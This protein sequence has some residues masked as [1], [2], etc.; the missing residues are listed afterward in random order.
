M[1]HAAPSP[2]HG[3]LP[4]RTDHGPR[5]L[6]RVAIRTA[7]AP[8]SASGAMPRSAQRATARMSTAGCPMAPGASRR[9]AVLVRSVGLEVPLSEIY[10]FAEI[11]EPGANEATVLGP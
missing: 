5:E 7:A 6:A 1:A 4:V 11:A 10:A 2:E 3:A 9:C 8:E